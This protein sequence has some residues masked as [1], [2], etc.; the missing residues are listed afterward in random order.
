M[1]T[2]GDFEV[3]LRL[4][5]VLVSKRSWSSLGNSRRMVEVGTVFCYGEKL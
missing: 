3:R 1:G 4:L 2:E 5:D